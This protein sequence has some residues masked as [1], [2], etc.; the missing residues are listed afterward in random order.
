MTT[1][2]PVRLRG[3]YSAAML[4]CADC[5]TLLP[6]EADAIISDPPYG[7][8]WDT[9]STRFS[10]GS[11][12]RGV[13]RDNYGTVLQDNAPFDPSPWLCYPVCV[14]F[15][16]NHF[17]QRLPVGTTLVWVKKEPHLWGTFL[18]DAEV[19]WMKGGTGVYLHLRSFPPPARVVDRGGDSKNPA[20][21]HP[22][23]KPVSL[24]AWCMERANVPAGATVLDPYMGS[25]T[26]GVACARTH[27]NF[28]GVEIDPK[29]FENAVRRIQ[30]EIEQQLI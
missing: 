11:V 27:R 29:H 6:L 1:V 14:L 5:L 12:K 3:R 2:E 21:I 26:T 10:G 22:T 25:G 7:M 19:A 8:D 28:I 24:M 18:S 9:D 30:R 23:Q 13:G 20:G 17:A 4:Y 15:G 16:A